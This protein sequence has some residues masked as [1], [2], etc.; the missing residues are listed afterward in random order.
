MEANIIFLISKD[1]TTNILIFIS[2]YLLAVII[3]KP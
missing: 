3:V 1:T 2:H